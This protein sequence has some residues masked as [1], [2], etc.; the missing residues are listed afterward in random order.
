MQW[1]SESNTGL[2]G[3]VSKK[4]PT[5]SKKA[6]PH[7]KTIGRGPAPQRLSTAVRYLIFCNFPLLVCCSEEMLNAPPSKV[8]S[9]TSVEKGRGFSDVPWRKRAF[10]PGT[11][12]VFFRNIFGH[13]WGLVYREGAPLVRYLCTT[14][15]SL[16][17]FFTIRGAPRMVPSTSLLNYFWAFLGAL[18]RGEGAPLVRYLCKTQKSLHGRHV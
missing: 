3:T 5:V 11:K 13:S 4:A 6:P 1:E 15:E 14:W 17:M 7:S 10:G 18:G 16:H 9:T 8:H 2:T 12:Y